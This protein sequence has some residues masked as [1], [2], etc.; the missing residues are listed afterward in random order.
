[1][2]LSSV[3]VKFQGKMLTIY[4]TPRIPKTAKWTIHEA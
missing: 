1:M 2:I 4:I 3:Y